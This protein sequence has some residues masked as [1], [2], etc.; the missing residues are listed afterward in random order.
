MLNRRAEKNPHC[1]DM[2]EICSMAIAIDEFFADC[3]ESI[4]P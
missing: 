2:M 3:I 4:R 1:V